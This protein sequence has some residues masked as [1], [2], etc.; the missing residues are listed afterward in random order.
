MTSLLTLLKQKKLMHFLTRKGIEYLKVIG[1]TRANTFASGLGAVIT[2][3]LSGNMIWSIAFASMAEGSWAGKLQYILHPKYQKSPPLLD[4]R[5]CYF[6][7]R[8]II[9]RKICLEECYHD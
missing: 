1:L 2:Y 4:A 8:S 6:T 7:H 5:C 3:V 9:R